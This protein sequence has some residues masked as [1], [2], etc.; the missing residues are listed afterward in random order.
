MQYEQKNDE[1]VIN[2]QNNI[3]E[4]IIE[5]YINEVKTQ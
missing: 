3:P 1:L 2:R 4:T 5:D